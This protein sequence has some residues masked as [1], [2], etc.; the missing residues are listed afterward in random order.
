MA[1]SPFDK[2]SAGS[3]ATASRPAPA[4]ASRDDLPDATNVGESA[5]LSKTAGADP[6]SASDPTGI[7]GYKPAFFLGQLVLMHPTEFGSMKTSSNTPENPTS[8]FVR[9]D[10]IALTV[11]EAGNLSRNP[12]VAQ[13][14]VYAVLD[15]DGDTQTCEP[16]SVGER[17]DDVLVFNKPLVR[18][19]KKALDNGTAWLLGRIT[20][21]QK[22]QGQSAPTILVAGSD[23]DKVIY[24]EWRTAAMAAR[25]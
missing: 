5:P 14:D 7:S 4:A 23:E 19:G 8:D 21:G 18:E 3:T 16:Y 13:G 6:F 1:G 17:I 15:K 9:F 2:K 20:L 11:P 12:V 25:R 24:Q 22:K 10:I